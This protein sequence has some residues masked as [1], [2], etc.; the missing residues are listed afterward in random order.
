M[1]RG[2]PKFVKFTA[3]KKFSVPIIEWVAFPSDCVDYFRPSLLAG[4]FCCGRH[5]D[6]DLGLRRHW[7]L[8]LR[9]DANFDEIRRDATRPCCS[10]PGLPR[11][12]VQVHHDPDMEEGHLPPT[13]Y[14]PADNSEI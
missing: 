11:T 1:G 10:D 2:K 14:W 13:R 3:K 6:L 4:C 7:H 5:F 8:D 12:R 9:R